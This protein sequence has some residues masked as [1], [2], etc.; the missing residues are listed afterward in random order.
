[1]TLGPVLL[2]L[3]AGTPVFKGLLADTDSRWACFEQAVDD[4]TDAEIKA[5][6]LPDPEHPSARTTLP[7]A[8]LCLPQ[9]DLQDADYDD[10][11][12][13]TLEAE[14]MH[15]NLAGHFGYI[16]SRDPLYASRQA[17]NN[18]DVTETKI[19]EGMLANVYQTVGSKPPPDDRTGW[20]VEFRTMESQLTD[21]EN[22]A[23]CVFAILAA[24]LIIDTK[25]NLH[26]PL[27]D[28]EESMRN[29]CK[30]DAA[31]GAESSSAALRST[32]KTTRPSQD[33]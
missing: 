7:Q 3:T 17:V 19:L 14:G 31:I 25:L 29:A 13:A 16:L 28:V 33:S 4:R 9:F 10:E 32:A 12:Y 24:R 5:A 22:T 1:M 15:N 23:F 27:K 21:F 26:V 6:S 18:G 2:A 30:R 8:R 20:R 11:I